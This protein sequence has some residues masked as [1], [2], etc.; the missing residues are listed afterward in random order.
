MCLVCSPAGHPPRDQTHHIENVNNWEAGGRALQAAI[1]N[2]RLLLIIDD[3]WS[4]RRLWPFR[5][6]EHGGPLSS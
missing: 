3:A 4:I 6:E 1:G 5:L 2:R